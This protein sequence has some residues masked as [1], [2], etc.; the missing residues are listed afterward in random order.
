MSFYPLASTFYFRLIT[1]KLFAQSRNRSGDT[2]SDSQIFYFLVYRN[3]FSPH[4]GRSRVRNL[5]TSICYPPRFPTHLW[6]T[7]NRTF[8]I[9]SLNGSSFESAIGLFLLLGLLYLRWQTPNAYCSHYGY[10]I[11][12]SWGD[13]SG[14][15]IVSLF[16]FS[17][18]ADRKRTA[19][20][21][22]APFGRVM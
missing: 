4:T 10:F 2:N 3:P 18:G 5:S 13:T 14:L 9:S 8:F 1:S 17:P 21:A 11:S 19:H 7:A 15:F 12:T 22:R 20:L 6:V 16:M